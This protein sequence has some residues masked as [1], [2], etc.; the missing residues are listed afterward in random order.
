MTNIVINNN[1]RFYILW[2][3]T[4]THRKIYTHI[5][6]NEMKRYAYNYLHRGGNNEN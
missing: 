5:I 2:P 1:K 6:N 4:C 3:F